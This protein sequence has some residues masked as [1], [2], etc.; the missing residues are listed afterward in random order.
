MLDHNLGLLVPL[1]VLAAC[2]IA[3]KNSSSL[4]E[5][6][7]CCSAE[8]QKFL[9]WDTAA[10]NMAKH[11]ITSYIILQ[12]IFCIY[13]SLHLEWNDSF[14]SITCKKEKK[15]N[16]VLCLEVKVLQNKRG[17]SFFSLQRCLLIKTD[18]LQTGWCSTMLLWLKK[19]RKKTCWKSLC[20]F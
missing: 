16:H 1:N 3:A 15:K 11:L 8:V 12:D 13:D 20:V 17:S 5:S 19:K 18:F 14:I 9:T 2:W 4:S 10:G 7:L 6:K